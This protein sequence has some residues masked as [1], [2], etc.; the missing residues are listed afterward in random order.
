MKGTDMKYLHFIVLLVSILITAGCTSGGNLIAGENLKISNIQVR[1]SEV[2]PVTGDI[3]W[4]IDFDVQNI[5]S[6]TEYGWKN[7][8]GH[9]N[10]YSVKVLIYDKNGEFLCSAGEM[11]NSLEP[12]EKTHYSIW[13]H[14]HQSR[15]TEAGNIDVKITR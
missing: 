14:A 4:H 7:G 13:C 3:I 8:A 9:P 6:V 5:G 2:Q 1:H 10:L 11:G 12:K 15:S